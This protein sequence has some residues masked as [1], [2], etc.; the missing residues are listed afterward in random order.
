ML[1]E[2][3]INQSKLSICS[4]CIYDERVPSIIFDDA[5]VCNYC[6]QIDSLTEQYGTGKRKGELI[7]QDILE[8]IKK[9]GKSK[10]YDCVVGVSGGTDSSFLI[11]KAATAW[12][13]RPLAVH[14]D[15]TWNT[16]SATINIAKVLNPLNI[17]LKTLVVNNKEADDLIKSFFLAGVPE[18][19]APTDLGFA[20][21]LRQVAAKYNIKYVL[22]GHSFVEEGISPLGKNYFDGKYISEIHNKYGKDKMKTY[23][24]MTFTRFIWSSLFHRVKFVR[25]L[26]YVQYSK[27]EAKK[28]LMEKFDWEDYGGHHLENRI[29]AF[30][31]RIYQPQKFE[32]DNRN[33]TLAA[34]ARNGSK[35]RTEA[36]AEYNQEICFEN[37]LVS[38][39]KKRLRLTDEQY[40]FIMR[41][42]P[43]YWTDYPTYKK[44]FEKFRPLFYLLAKANLVPMSFYLKYCFPVKDLK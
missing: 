40:N 16:A 10:P 19:D 38:Y 35:S 14:Y 5:G 22:E 17:D 33:L 6:H 9:K 8:D 43:K 30:C 1:N 34:L 21:L 13:L 3:D 12:G 20:Y 18:I 25:P 39:F 41:S 4:R 2:P 15:N 23:P 36:W 37:D 32:I 31:T 29:A 11:Y 7:F 24:L 42:P 26:W 44:L 28:I 27:S